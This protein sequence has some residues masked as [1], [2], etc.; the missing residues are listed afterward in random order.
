MLSGKSNVKPKPKTL[1][2]LTATFRFEAIGTQWEITLDRTIQNDLITALMESIRQRIEEF[3][4]NYS[5]FRSDSLISTIASEAGRYH[6]PDDAAALLELYKQ[7]YDLTGGLMTPLIGQALSDAGY[8]AQYSLRS[9]SVQATPSWSATI[10]YQYPNLLVKRPVLLD[11][12]AIGKG[13]LVD[14]VARL[15]EDAG[16]TDFCVNAGGDML[17]R[18]T[19]SEPMRVGLEHPDH[20]DEVIGVVDLSNQ[21]LCGS[22][23]NRRVWE[24]F[25][26]IINPRTRTSPTHLKAIWVIAGTTM[27]ADA[28]ST[29]LFFTP[30][31]KL[32]E[33]YTFEYTI[34][35]DD[36]SL[37]HSP[38]FPAEYFTD[39]D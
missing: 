30:A 37:E 22:A 27:L 4:H 36:Y 10:A 39:K 32:A 26:H 8:D 15:I 1:K 6:L 35:H 16:I 3:D 33:E 20:P 9:G 38:D 17:Q 21:S 23:G 5:R 24:D 25:N 7:L 19:G 2:A 13:Y 28:L 34:I 29:A 18:Q 11:L 12:G 31:S 14:I